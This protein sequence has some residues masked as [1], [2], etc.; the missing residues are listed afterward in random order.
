MRRQSIKLERRE[1]MKLEGKK[2][3]AGASEVH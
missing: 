2:I 3:L 1:N